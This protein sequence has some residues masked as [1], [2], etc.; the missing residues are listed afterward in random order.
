MG[1][2]L[3]CPIQGLYKPGRVLTFQGQFEFD[4]FATAELCYKFADQFHWSPAILASHLENIKRS[5][6]PGKEDD[7][8]SKAAAEAVLLFFAGEDQSVDSDLPPST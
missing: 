7:D 4:A 5:A 1:S 8:D 2:S 3:K 6:V